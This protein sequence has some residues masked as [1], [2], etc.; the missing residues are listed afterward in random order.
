MRSAVGTS[1][2][3]AVVHCKK[4][5][6]ASVATDAKESLEC[7]IVMILLCVTEGGNATVPPLSVK[8]TC[9]ELRS[10]VHDLCHQLGRI[11]QHFARTFKVRPVCR[12]A[13]CYNSP[14]VSAVMNFWG[15]S[16][17]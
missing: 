7:R 9:T 6:R 17:R 10:L 16:I 11:F 3:H 13:P 1:Q 5:A 15:I 4:I 14:L 2:A 12:C 8:L